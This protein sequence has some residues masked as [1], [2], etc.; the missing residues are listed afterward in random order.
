V[1]LPALNDEAQLTAFV[2]YVLLLCTV[3]LSVVFAY[4]TVTGSGNAGAL[5]G[6]LGICVTTMGGLLGA[7]AIRHSSSN[8]DSSDE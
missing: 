1:K 3:F 4:S 2:V 7:R 6:F 5:A 8:R